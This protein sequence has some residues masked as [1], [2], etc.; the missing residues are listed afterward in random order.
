[1]KSAS[2]T[3]SSRDDSSSLSRLTICLPRDLSARIKQ[4]A[5]A[6]RRSTSSQVVHLLERALK[7][8][9]KA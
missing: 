1:M 6:E 3:R 2:V 8:R 4:D 9:R 5:T 7:G